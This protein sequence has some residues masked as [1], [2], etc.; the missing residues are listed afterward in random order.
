MAGNDQDW[1]R[2][3]LAENIQQLTLLHLEGGPPSETVVGTCAAWLRVLNNWPIVWN[4]A[5]DRPRLNAAFLVLAGQSPRWPSPSQLR[6]LLPAREYPQDALPGPGYPEAKAAANRAKIKFLLNAAF[7]MRE[8]KDE[9][10]RLEAA[11]Q[12]DLAEKTL[13][14]LADLQIEIDKLQTQID[15]AKQL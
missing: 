14:K 6:A 10:A 5:L 1:L 7:R 4:E 11:Y 2:V 13:D 9:Y 3:C 12:K 8:L 15:E